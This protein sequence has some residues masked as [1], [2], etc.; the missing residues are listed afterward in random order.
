MRQPS[1]SELYYSSAAKIDQH[2]RSRQSDLGIE[3]K[4]GTHDW[5]KRVNLSIFSMI[6]VDALFVYRECTLSE[7]TPN[8]FFH[9]LAEEMID[10][11]CT[12]RAQ[13]AAAKDDGP[14]DYQGRG[15]RLTPTK[16]VRPKDAYQLFQ[17]RCVTCSK[18]STWTC[19]ICKDAGKPAFVCHTKQRQSCWSIHKEL[20]QE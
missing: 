17:A 15:P 2:N 14:T 9:K 8:H 19:S 5:A 18:K 20:E 7:E 11:K 10:Y 16:R 3:L 12:T 13:K 6:V 1:A 4:L